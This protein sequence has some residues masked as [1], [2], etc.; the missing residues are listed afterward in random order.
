[1]ER[2][3]LNEIMQNNLT[4]NNINKVKTLLFIIKFYTM[5]EIFRIESK[6]IEIELK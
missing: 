1:M 4:I 5:N 6:W 2:D 3:G